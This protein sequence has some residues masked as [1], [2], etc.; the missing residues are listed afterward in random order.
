MS[1]STASAW[2]SPGHLLRLVEAPLQ[3]DRLGEM[4]TAEQRS[5]RP[6]CLKRL[7]SFT[8]H[9]LGRGRSLAISSI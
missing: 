6:P 3:V 8:Q 7:A 1:S 9:A 5:P 2:D 4:A